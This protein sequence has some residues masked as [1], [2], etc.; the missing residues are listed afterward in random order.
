MVILLPF[1]KIEFFKSIDFSYI[2]L[3]IVVNKSLACLELLEDQ[4]INSNRN[5]DLFVKNIQNII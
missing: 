2:H 4:L 3:L 5:Y 1:N